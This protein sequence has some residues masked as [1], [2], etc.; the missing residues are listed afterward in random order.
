MEKCPFDLTPY[1]IGAS[2]SKPQ[3]FSLN[4]TNQDFWSMKTRLVN[5]IQENFGDKFNDFVESSLG[6]MLI[7]NWAFIADTLS[8][9]I[10][11]IANEV[12]IDTV[13]ELS[14]AFRLAQLVGFEP[15]PPIAGKSLWSARIPNTFTV[16]L[17]IQT[18]YV[19][20]IVNGEVSTTIELFSADPLNRPIFDEDIIIPAGELINTNI[21]GIQGRT[22]T[23]FFTSNGGA[24]QSYLLSFNPVLLD[25][26]RVYVDGT[27]WEQVKFFTDSEARL[28]YRIEFTADYSVFIIFGSNRAG[29]IPSV[30][31]NIKV[32]YRVGGGTSGNIVSNYASAEA[33]VPI[34]GQV[35]NAV[36]N[37]TNYTK[38]EFGYSGDTI[39]DIRYK[40]PVYAQTQN[41]CVSGSDYKNFA[42][43]FATPYNGTM[44]KANAVLR[45][46]G[47]SANII[48]MYILVK[49]DNYNLAKANSQFKYEFQEYI[50]QQ[51][52]LTDY[53][54]V[55]DGEIIYVDIAVN[56]VMDKYYKKFQDEIKTQITNRIL[57]FF[58]LSNWDY[59]QILRDIDIVKTLSDMQQPKRY[60]I[61]F[62]TTN[63]QNGGKQVVARY[64]EI[65]RPENIQVN[66]TYE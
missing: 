43:L 16:D 65:I 32:V 17:R 36:I 2:T 24:N 9:K 63:P 34:D 39:D 28:E 33:L 5:Y 61:N 4:Y 3:V 25:S 60:E 56:V 35:F 66:F 45:H 21:V 44:G 40:L 51:K 58:Q 14:N 46:S 30:G 38:G 50:D 59:A 15:T 23:D 55:K 29:Y 10:D 6:I 26:I 31:S 37:L 62:V 64:F 49:E 48:E 1:K 13:T 20:D 18:P 12:F 11:Q 42:N 8:F 57:A 27:Q 7:E 41:R 52:M 22:Y 47:C 53:I 54:V 19:V